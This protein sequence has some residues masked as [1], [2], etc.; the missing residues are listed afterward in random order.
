M[1]LLNDSHLV[2]PPEPN[3]FLCHFCDEESPNEWHNQ[4]NGKECCDS[5]LEDIKF[6]A[7]GKCIG[8]SCECSDD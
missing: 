1:T 5:C 8:G 7:C 4:V 2:T 3:Y 6:E